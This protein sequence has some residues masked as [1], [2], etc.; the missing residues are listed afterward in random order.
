VILL[1][2]CRESEAVVVNV[3][4]VQVVQ[5]ADLI[6]Q[7]FESDTSN[8]WKP[9][10]E[11]LDYK[12]QWTDTSRRRELLEIINNPY[13]IGLLPD[14]N[15]NAER[16]SD[17]W[18]Q[19]PL[20][21]VKGIPLLAE[22]MSTHLMH[23]LVQRLEKGE[24]DLISSACPDSA[25]IEKLEVLL[26]S[27]DLISGLTDYLGP[28]LG[29]KWKWIERFYGSANLSYAPDPIP[30]YKKDSTAS[31]E[32]VLSA[33][34]EYG[35]IDDIPDSLL[36]AD[37][38]IYH[39]KQFQLMNGLQ[40]DGVIGKRTRSALEKTNKERYGQLLANLERTRNQRDWQ[41]GTA[42]IEVNV[43]EFVVRFFIDGELVRKHKVI[44]GKRKKHKTPNFKASLSE[45]VINPTWHV[46]YSISTK[47]LLPKQQNDSCYLDRHEYVVYDRRKNIVDPILIDW[48]ELNLHHFPY[49]IVQQPGRINALGTIKFLFPNK[50]SVYL[51]DT[52]SR[53]LFAREE[54]DFSHGCVRL[55]DPYPLALDILEYS[56]S[57]VDSVEFFALLDTAKIYSIPIYPKIP[58][59]VNY[60][61]VGESE[62]GEYLIFFDDL[63]KRDQ[64][65]IDKVR[66]IGY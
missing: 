33:L 65:W 17:Y 12:P 35:L 23:F 24:A 62:D 51:H 38:I 1:T 58:V 15:L 2:G 64:E 6:R 45:I 7:Y 40:P 34:T 36:T 29:T 26:S 46:P 13:S 63:Y 18:K 66:D 3:P 5:P 28:D 53:R 11:A 10:Y 25:A 32:A 60:G 59:I 16:F 14:S 49:D 19:Y 37:T 22:L 61:T 54:R 56:Q 55:E 31:M 52:P 42:Y 21:T 50:Y 9:L 8:C 43:P 27:H 48:D 30:D 4:E 44:V 20:D 41:K 57:K 47:E 39:L